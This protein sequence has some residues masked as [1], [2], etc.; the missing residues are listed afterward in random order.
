MTDAHAEQPPPHKHKDAAKP[1][2][3]ELKQRRLSK[4]QR[5]KLTK[6]WRNWTD[7]FTPDDC[8]GPLLQQSSFATL[9][10]QYREAY[11]RQVWPAVT[12]QLHKLGVA[13]ELNLVEG[14][15]TVSTT[16]RTWDPYAILN[17]R[18][19]IKLLARSVPLAQAAK[20]LRDGVN[21]DI[22]KIGSM[23][24]N[25]ER[26]VKRRQRLIGPNGSTLK[27]LELLTECYILVQ[28]NTA[29]C[30]GSFKGLREARR[31]IEDCMDNIHP[32]Y[33]IKTMMIVRQ[34]HKDEKLRTESWD[35]FLPKF[36]KKNIKRKKRPQSNNNDT[37]REYSAFPPL[38]KPSKVDLQLESGEYF[39]SEHSR[40][41]KRVAEQ[42]E[43][44]REKS[45]LKQAKRERAY[46]APREPR[47]R[48]GDGGDGGEDGGDEEGVEELAKRVKKRARKAAKQ[49]S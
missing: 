32:V 40:K 6:P 1:T 46:E 22:I 11:L 45:A 7:T 47:A 30:M 43:A 49:G 25:R 31:V 28:G 10:P 42:K 9:F 4:K 14:S 12:A 37:A 41:R 24:H 19:L 15:M 21:C 48:G 13:A 27:A 3:E 38:P 17:A 35:R 26:F 36:K 2:R 29:A 18:D 8:T 20:I 34:L 39:M 44:R 16:R 5:H 33:N 23:V